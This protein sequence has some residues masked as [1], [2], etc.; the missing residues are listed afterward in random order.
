MQPT[1]TTVCVEWCTE[2]A[3]NSAQNSI[4]IFNNDSDMPQGMVPSNGWSNFSVTG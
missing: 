2:E 1:D 3:S 4:H